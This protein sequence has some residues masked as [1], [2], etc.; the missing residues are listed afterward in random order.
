MGA[1]GYFVQISSGL[2]LYRLQSKSVQRLKSE[3]STYRQRY[4]RIL[5]SKVSKLVTPRFQIVLKKMS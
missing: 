5:S 3:K 1:S 4:F 2:Q